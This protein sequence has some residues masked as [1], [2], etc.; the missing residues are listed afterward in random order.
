[1]PLLLPNLGPGCRPGRVGTTRRNSAAAPQATPRLHES[2]QRTYSGADAPNGLV[3]PHRIV[4][5]C[6]N[7]MPLDAAEREIDDGAD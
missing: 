4:D 1:V 2:V 5:D 7:R 6:A 3:I